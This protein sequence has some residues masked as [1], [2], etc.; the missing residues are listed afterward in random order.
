MLKEQIKTNL[1]TNKN[2]HQLSKE[3]GLWVTVNPRQIYQQK[4]TFIPHVKNLPFHQGPTERNPKP[5]LLVHLHKKAVTWP[6]NRM[7][8]KEYS[9]FLFAKLCMSYQ[10]LIY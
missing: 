8:K 7:E 1:V 2:M 10:L 9:S 5:V 3:K 6:F 4:V